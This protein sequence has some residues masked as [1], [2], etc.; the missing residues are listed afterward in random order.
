MKRDKNQIAGYKGFGQKGCMRSNHLMDM[1][2]WGVF[3]R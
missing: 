2:L 1:F 3:M